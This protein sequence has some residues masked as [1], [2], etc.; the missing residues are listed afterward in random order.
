MEKTPTLE[1]DALTADQVMQKKA[2]VYEEA[3]PAEQKAID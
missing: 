3:R 1:I 2:F